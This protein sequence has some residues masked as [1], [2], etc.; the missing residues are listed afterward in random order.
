MAIE[1]I[2]VCGQVLRANE[3]HV[4]CQVRCP[5]CRVDLVIPSQN[6]PAPAPLLPTLPVPEASPEGDRPWWKDPIIVLGS[7]L[8]LLLGLIIWKN[9]PSKVDLLAG[10]YASA[11]AKQE[12][13]DRGPDQTWAENEIRKY[14][15]KTHPSADVIVDELKFIGGGIPGKEK[16]MKFADARITLLIG[17][18]LR[19]FRGGFFFNKPPGETRE[20]GPIVLDDLSTGETTWSGTGPRTFQNLLPRSCRSN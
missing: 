2:C 13:I 4:G 6:G 18:S 20:M 3:S 1:F 14:F 15:G 10:K 7:L 9:Q 5:A 11:L 12:Q 8:V 19:K 16:Y 17:E